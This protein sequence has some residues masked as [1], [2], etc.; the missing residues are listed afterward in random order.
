VKHA[1][2]GTLAAGR[3][4]KA[5]LALTFAA[6]ATARTPRVSF[7]VA[8]ARWLNRLRGAIKM[9]HGRRSVS[10]RGPE[11]KSGQS[12][13]A[14]EQ[15]LAGTGLFFHDV[16]SSSIEF[17]CQYTHST[18]RRLRQWP[19][20]NYLPPLPPLLHQGFP[21][22]FPLQDGLTAAFPVLSR[23]STVGAI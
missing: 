4:K 12:L 2:E 17:F 23:C 19:Q 3:R 15:G 1:N 22:E 21:L 20:D 11:S 10:D 7:A 9:K 8:V 14:T 18:S 5:L 16:Q 6:A 13:A